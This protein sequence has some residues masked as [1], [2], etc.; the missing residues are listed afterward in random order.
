MLWIHRELSQLSDS[1][2]L[3]YLTVKILMEF[4][5]IIIK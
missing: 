5:S 1:S 4:E 2:S 3:S